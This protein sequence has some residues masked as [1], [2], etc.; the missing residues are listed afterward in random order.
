MVSL[1]T[2]PKN[3]GEKAKNTWMTVEK[4]LEKEGIYVENLWEAC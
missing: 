3:T 4:L 1:W 2:N